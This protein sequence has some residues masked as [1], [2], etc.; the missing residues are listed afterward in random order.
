MS[1]KTEAPTMASDRVACGHSWTQ[2]SENMCRTETT[3]LEQTRNLTHFNTS[4]H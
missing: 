3:R 2:E 1:K 4:N